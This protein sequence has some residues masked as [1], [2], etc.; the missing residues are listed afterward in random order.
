MSEAAGRDARAGSARASV[1]AAVCAALP[2]FLP[3]Q[4][5]YGAKGRR[6]SRVAIRDVADLGDDPRALLTVIDVYGDGE[7]PASYFLPLGQWPADEADAPGEMIVS[8]GDLAVRD[9]IYDPDTC[10]ALL[11]GILEGRSLPTANGGR[12]VFERAGGQQAD[13]A[14]RALADPAQL[15]VRNVNVEQSNSSV[16]FGD[17]LILKA[18]R[19]LVVGVHPEVEI[20]RFLSER[21]TFD[22]TP[23]MLGWADYH[24][25]DGSIAPVAV[26]QRFVPN[27]GDGWSNVLARLRALADAPDGEAPLVASLDAL[28]ATLGGLHLALASA[29]DDPAFAPEVISAADLDRWRARTHASLD[30]AL[31]AIRRELA[32]DDPT[33]GWTATARN[34]GTATLYGERRLRAAVDG[35]GVLADGRVAKT[36][37]HGDFHLGQTLVGEDGWYIIDFEGEPARSLDERRAKQTPL[38]DVAG[39]LR[40]LDYAEATVVREGVVLPDPSLMDRLR[41][42]F[43]ASYVAAVRGSRP[44]ILP[45][46]PDELAAALLALEAEK[47]IYELGYELSN[48]P[49]WVEIPLSALARLAESA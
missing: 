18:L 43:L 9:A 33:A 20:T 7:Q 6:I 13:A 11:A 42:R 21:T 30:G 47:A 24:A 37:H 12:L 46:H 38:R 16:I 27:Q 19:R 28:G 10:R 5:W 15:A 44:P 4:R 49:D 45:S 3:A 22:R 17:A 41:A 29:S 26:L 1:L 32:R 39:L 36:R 2:R 23:A 8:V 34:L 14:F 35:V 40:S 48:R 31:T 25:P